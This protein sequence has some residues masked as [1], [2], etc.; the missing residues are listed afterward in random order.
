M[1]SHSLTGTTAAGSPWITL[2]HSHLSCHNCHSHHHTAVH[3][4]PSLSTGCLSELQASS[5]S[6][7]SHS[8][9]GNTCHLPV[10]L[11]MLCSQDAFPWVFSLH[12][13]VLG[14]EYRLGSEEP[15]CASSQEP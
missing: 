2:T 4:A 1:P 14:A 8:L 5:P 15:L 13:L 10:P 3:N 11:A 12:S 6:L 9:L 7:A